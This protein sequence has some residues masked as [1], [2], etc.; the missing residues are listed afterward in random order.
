MVRPAF[1][2]IACFS[3][4]ISFKVSIDILNFAQKYYK[5]KS[6]PQMKQIELF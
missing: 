3:F 5:K 6:C 4:S 1:F 2:S